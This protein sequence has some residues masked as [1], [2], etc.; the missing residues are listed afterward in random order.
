[1]FDEMT[2]LSKELYQK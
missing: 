1:M 2:F